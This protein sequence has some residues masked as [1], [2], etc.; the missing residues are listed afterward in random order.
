MDNTILRLRL[1]NQSMSTYRKGGDTLTKLLQDIRKSGRTLFLDVIGIKV[2]RPRREGFG[3]FKSYT[4]TIRFEFFGGKVMDIECSGAIE[5]YIKL[6]SVK[7][8]K[9]VP[10]SK[11]PASDTE[12]WVTPKIYKGIS[13]QEQELLNQ[14]D[15]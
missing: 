5:K 1:S 12:E 6:R 8:L 15:E 9:V 4:R 13:M 3:P 14:E 10:K 11:P 2:T 7:S